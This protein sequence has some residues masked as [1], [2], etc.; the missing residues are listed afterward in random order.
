MLIAKTI[1]LF[2]IFF[3]IPRLF[4]DLSIHHASKPLNSLRNAPVVVALKVRLRVTLGTVLRQLVAIIPTVVLPVAEQPLRNAPIVGLARATRPTGRTVPLPA[5]VR[6][7][8]RIV[9][10]VVVKVTHPQ[11]RNAA[12]VL[13]AELRVRIARSFV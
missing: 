3:V 1:P 9:P 12:P 2:E 8:V 5:H 13:A 7:L 10:A 4:P 11:L 6:R